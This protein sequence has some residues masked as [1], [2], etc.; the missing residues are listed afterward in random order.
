MARLSHALVLTAGLGTRLDPL[1]RVRAKPAV[2]VAGEALVRRII[3]GLVAQSVTNLVLNLHHLPATI[4]AVVGDGQDLGA[5]VRYSWEQ[6][7]I[8]GSAGGPALALPLIEA[9]TFAI[10]NGDT[11]SDVDLAGLASAHRSGGA[12]VTLAVTPNREPQKYGG[13]RMKADGDVTGFV[14][15]GTAA[16]GSFHFV[17][18]QIVEAEVFRTV[19]P[20]VPRAVIGGGRPGTGNA[21]VYDDLILHQQG[22][23]RAVVLETTF[24]DVGTVADYFATC[25]SLSDTPPD[26]VVAGRGGMIDPSATVTRSIL[27]DD[28]E[29]GAGCRLDGCIVTD[30]VR[31]PAGRAFRDAVLIETRGEIESIPIEHTKQ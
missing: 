30:G 22:C 6:P 12:L 2:P 15:R 5:A 26:R 10:V 7:A 17:G 3:R 16:E 31:V 8:L 27:W 23:V 20:G 9:S 24:R 4:A 29:V 28:V 25:L 11:L 21:G 19:P 18:V 14:P 13:V 1:T